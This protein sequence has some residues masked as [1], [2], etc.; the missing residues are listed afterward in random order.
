MLVQGFIIRNNVKDYKALPKLPVLNFN[1][2]KIITSCTVLL[3][4]TVR[5]LDYKAL[6]NLNKVKVSF[7]SDSFA[8]HGRAR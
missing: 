2:V 1:K 6:S 8:M 4:K 7:D 3:S 5:N